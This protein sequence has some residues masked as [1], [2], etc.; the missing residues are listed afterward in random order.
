V[1]ANAAITCRESSTRVESEVQFLCRQ[2][3]KWLLG[4]SDQL[5]SATDYS[6]ENSIFII[7][8]PGQPVFYCSRIAHFHFLTV[9][10]IHVIPV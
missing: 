1:L 6:L 3:G 7:F 9:F 4:C 10:R 8:M 5:A 2:L